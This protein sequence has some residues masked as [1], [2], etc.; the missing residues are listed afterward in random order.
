M[1]LYDKMIKQCLV[2]RFEVS[3]YAVYRFLKARNL[4]RPLV[5]ASSP[6]NGDVLSLC[7]PHSI[8]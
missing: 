7:L 4:A 5:D 2:L 3:Y 6:K 8:P 1:L